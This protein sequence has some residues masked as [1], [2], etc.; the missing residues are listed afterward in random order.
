MLGNVSDII[1]LPSRS[2]FVICS[3]LVTLSDGG[4]VGKGNNVKN[5]EPSEIFHRVLATL[6]N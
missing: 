5:R 1:W 2:N 6:E 3:S 4:P